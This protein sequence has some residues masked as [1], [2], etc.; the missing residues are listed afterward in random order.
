MNPAIAGIIIIYYYTYFERLDERPEQ[1][2]Y[3]V[4]LPEQFYQ[5]CGP[6]EPEESD[7][8]EVFLQKQVFVYHTWRKTVRKG[9][10]PVTV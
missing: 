6:E 1:Y 10:R 5:S 7:V 9:P 8:Y 2:P 4:P 3:S